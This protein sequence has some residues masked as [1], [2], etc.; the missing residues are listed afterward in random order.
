M[1]GESDDSLVW[2]KV[3]AGETVNRREFL[4]VSGVSVTEIGST[5]SSRGQP[6]M[7]IV[8]ESHYKDQPSMVLENHVIRAEFVAQGGRM[9]SLRDK[10]VDHE[11]L[12]QQ[13]AAKYIR[14]EYDQPMANDQAAGYDDMIP[15]IAE[16]HYQHFPWK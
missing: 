13:E 1:T 3:D 15:T 14:S 12:F 6:A 8:R 11:F 2:V 9:V 16:C 4:V 7:P 5:K 10:R